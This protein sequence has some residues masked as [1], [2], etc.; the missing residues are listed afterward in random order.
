MR[1][2]RISLQRD[3]DRVQQLLLFTSPLD[4][5]L[6]TLLQKEFSSM[7]QM[8]VNA[9]IVDQQI[10]S[11]ST[12]GNIY[13]MSPDGYLF[14]YYPPYE[15]EQESL[16]HAEDLKVDLKKSIKGSRL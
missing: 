13:L 11:A 12:A 10:A 5:A 3:M 15:N 1:Q 9:E 6:A 14:I 4:A 8:Q 7:L 16:V 2:V